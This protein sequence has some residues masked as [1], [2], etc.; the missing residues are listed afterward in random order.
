MFRKFTKLY[1]VFLAGLIV[2]GG[3]SIFLSGKPSEEELAGLEEQT[4]KKTP[5]YA[6][7][8]S[9]SQIAEKHL[10]DD[11]V[12]D[13]QVSPNDNQEEALLQLQT[14]EFATEDALLKNTF[15]ILQDVQKLESLNTFTISWFRLQ[16]S[17]N[18]EVLS[19]TL[20]REALDQVHTIR[21]S[22]LPAIASVYEK[23]EILP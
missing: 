22:E 17:K 20:T 5:G 15:N 11:A 9:L 16:E 21:Y 19:L 13:I 1:I 7:M 4:A 23:H 18:T 12:L 8:T 3:V 2:I 10:M 6:T 14:T